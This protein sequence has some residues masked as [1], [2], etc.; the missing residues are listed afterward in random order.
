MNENK[1]T[2]IKNSCPQDHHC[3]IIGICPVGAILQKGNAAPE[4][5]QNK[6]IGCGMCINYCAYGAFVSAAD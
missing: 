3:P 2:V 1:I 4:I 5:D 6:C